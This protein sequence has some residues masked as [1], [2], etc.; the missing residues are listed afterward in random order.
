MKN[1]HTDEF[2]EE[3]HNLSKSSFSEDIILL[4]KRCLLDYL[5]ATIAG[6]HIMQEKGNTLLNYFAE[7]RGRSTVIGFSRKTSIENSIFIN[8]LSSHIAELDDGVRFGMVHPGSPIFSAMLPVAE[9]EKINGKDFLRGVITAYEA[10]I[11]VASSVQPFHYNAGYHPTGTIGTIGAAVGISAMLGFS[12]IQMKNSF[13]SAVLSASGSLKVLEDGS[14]LK[15]L[16][17]A[18]AAQKGFTSTLMSRSGFNGPADVFQGECGFFNMMTPRSNISELEKNAG[19]TLGIQKIYVKPYAACR[20]AHPS[21]EGMLE[22][23]SKYKILEKEIDHVIIR[24]YKAV[25]GKHDH[26]EIFG[27]SSAKMSIPFSAA[28]SL[29]LGQAGINDFCDENLKNHEINSLMK[30]IKVYSEAELTSLVPNK[31]AAIV[32][33]YTKNGRKLT[34]RVDYPKGEPENP[35]SDDELK[36][37]FTDLMKFANKSKEK[38]DKLIDVVFG[39]ENRLLELYPLL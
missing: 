3:I 23:R 13:S 32:E 37:K 4:A 28:L 20:H 15:P 18:N 38:S 39:L 2:I 5:G 16:N 33:V 34:K 7:E 11:R 21:I 8:G 27:I 35:L 36:V 14:E 12:K 25:I 19:S 24:T 9:K 1:N 31:R 22:I 30:R 6:A 29:V 17:V 26:N 10:T